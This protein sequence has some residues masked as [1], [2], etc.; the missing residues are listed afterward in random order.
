M[1]DNFHLILTYSMP[2]ESI[3]YSAL[4]ARPSLIA[5]D[6]HSREMEKY[7][8]EWDRLC[9]KSRMARARSGPVVA[10]NAMIWVYARLS[11]SRSARFFVKPP[12]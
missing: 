2:F 7:R 1:I 6:I 9:F 12:A 3:I 4:I 5:L 10:T 8:F 11:S